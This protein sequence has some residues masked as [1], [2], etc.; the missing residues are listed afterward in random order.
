MKKILFTLA[1]LVSFC[2]IGQ[3]AEDYI[4]RA[5]SKYDAGD[6]YGAIE[7]Y[8]KVIELEPNESSEIYLE[9][10]IIK[11]EELKDHYGAIAA[12]SKAIE[13]DPNNHEAYYEIGIAKYNLE[14]F[15]GALADINFY[16]GLNLQLP[17]P[18]IYYVR[19][20]IKAE[21]NDQYGAIS[22]F[23]K[24]IELDPN[25][26]DAFLLRGLSKYELGDMRGRCSDFIKASKLGNKYATDL[27]SKLCK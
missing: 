2:T 27:Y 16:L 18:Y 11:D 23:S 12:F 21:L 26:A 20:D 3:T 10:G 13:L 9:I 1:L 4:D 15:K 24:A 17:G 8:T 5:E 14:D 7:D 6:F 19:G 25:Y 22:D